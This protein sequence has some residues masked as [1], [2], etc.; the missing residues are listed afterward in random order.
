VGWVGV[1]EV[2]MAK[3][4]RTA[5]KPRDVY[6]QLR[7]LIVHGQVAP[8][9][10]LVETDLARR[11]GVSRTPLRAALQRLQQEGY[12]LAAAAAQQARLTVSPMT[13][14]DADELFLLVGTLEAQAARQAA[15]LASGAR[16]LLASRLKATN[17]ELKRTASGRRPHHD[18]L[19]E[20]DE[21]FHRLYVEA[22]AGPRL[23]ALHRAVKPQAERYERLYVSLLMSEITVS[24]QEHSKIHRAI[25]DG[26]SAAAFDAV[27]V[28]WRNAAARLSLVIA[29]AGERGSW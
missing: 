25:R 3:V 29:Q 4:R 23:L 17:D 1:A 10:R 27:L 28:N 13:S 7:D 6:A 8:G 2:T 19:F 24:V 22:G 20:L 16:Q 18:R 11:L 21:R 15:M 5:I 9:S 12:V 14:D 26:G